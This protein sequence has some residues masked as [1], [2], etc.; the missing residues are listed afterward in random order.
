VAV[1]LQP[2]Q[3]KGACQPVKLAAKS[4]AKS[5]QDQQQKQHN[6]RKPRV[7]S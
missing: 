2:M 7:K 4:P 3:R 1:P 6:N 5:D